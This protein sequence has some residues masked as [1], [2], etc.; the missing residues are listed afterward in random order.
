MI[1][2]KI[3]IDTCGYLYLNTGAGF[4]IMFIN[5]EHEP[6]FCD[7]NTNDCTELA[8]RVMKTHTYILNDNDDDVDYEISH[9]HKKVYD[10]ES[11]YDPHMEVKMHQHHMVSDDIGVILRGNKAGCVS[12]YDLTIKCDSTV[13]TTGTYP[14]D[15]IYQVTF[16]LNSCTLTITTDH[17]EYKYE[18][19]AVEGN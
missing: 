3:L 2:K 11:R 18:L 17:K 10:D 14:D 13:Y 8:E 12:P 5:N 19:E 4:Q 7:W 16:D 6:D 9:D 1:N 15:A